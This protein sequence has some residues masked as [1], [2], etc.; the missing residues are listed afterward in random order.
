MSSCDL[1]HCPELEVDSI[2]L[3]QH[4]EYL[5]QRLSSSKVTTRTHTQPHTHTHIHTGVIALS[6]Q[7][8]WS[9]IITWHFITT[10]GY[11]IRWFTAGGCN[12]HRCTTT[13][14][15]VEIT[16]LWRHWWRHNS[17]SIRDRQK[18]RPPRTWIKSMR[19]TVGK[20][21]KKKSG[22]E[23]GPWT[24]R[25]KWSHSAFWGITSVGWWERNELVK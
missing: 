11:A 10:S 18:R 20:I 7:I 1:E 13:F 16:S 3:N 12:P 23:A 14:A 22:D 5:G 21:I 6:G 24:D 17:E 19:T 8:R 15:N 25:E 4:N 2:E 9:V